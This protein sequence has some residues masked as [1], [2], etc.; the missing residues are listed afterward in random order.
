MIMA[1]SDIYESLVQ[2]NNI[3]PADYGLAVLPL[4]PGGSAGLLGGGTL[5]AVNVKASP[6]QQAISPRKSESS[7]CARADCSS[8]SS[9]A[10]AV[11]SPRSRSL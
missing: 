2:Q 11:I 6:K 7:M 8:G 3:K 4:A 5:A 9:S 1:G 10:R